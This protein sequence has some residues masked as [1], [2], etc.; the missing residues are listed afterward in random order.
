MVVIVDVSDLLQRI[1][2]VRE[3]LSTVYLI[4]YTD[5]DL[6]E[7]VMY[8]WDLSMLTE[9]TRYA[10]MEP[11]YEGDDSEL[12]ISVYLTLFTDVFTEVA[13]HFTKLIGD[14]YLDFQVLEWVSPVA[15][16]LIKDGT[17]LPRPTLDRVE[18]GRRYIV[19]M[20][21]VLNAKYA[22]DINT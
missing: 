21:E 10:F 15:I 5:K 1:H 19:S 13:N 2:E 14:N 12:I 20:T 22:R 6:L 16:T 8:F 11:S 17:N 9:H 3:S 7:W 18:E 4:P